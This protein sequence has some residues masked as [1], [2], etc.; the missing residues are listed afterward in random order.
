MWRCF[1]ARKTVRL[2]DMDKVRFG[3]A[4]GMGARQG[5]KA[6]MKAAD[7]ATTPDPRATRKA[8]AAVR[9]KMIETAG[10]AKATSAGVKEGGRRFGAAVWK[11]MVTASSVLWLEVTGVLFGMFALVTGTWTWSH[12][13]DLAAGGVLRQHEWIGVGLFSLFVYFTVSSYT[14]AAK[15]GRQ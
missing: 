11:P 5:A 15:R 13:Y 3:R 10:Q 9:G 7:A 1:P 4:L 2:W 12:R 6:L 8:G 14:R